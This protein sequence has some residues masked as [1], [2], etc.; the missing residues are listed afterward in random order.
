MNRVIHHAADTIGRRYLALTQTCGAAAL[1]LWVSKGAICSHCPPGFSGKPRRRTNGIELFCD[2]C[3]E[4]WDPVEQW[5]LRSGVN[6]GLPGTHKHRWERGKGLVIEPRYAARPKGGRQ[7]GRTD[8]S[9]A[10]LADHVD[11]LLRTQ[12]LVETVPAGTDPEA[13]CYAV[14]C[15]LALLALEPWSSDEPPT[16]KPFPGFEPGEGDAI[17]HVCSWGSV[18][19]PQLGPW[20]RWTQSSV[21]TAIRTAREWIGWRAQTPRWPQEESMDEREWVP[22]REAAQ[23]LGM[24]ERTLRD[25]CYDL[26]VPKAD[27]HVWRRPGSKRGGRMKI[28]EAAMPRIRALAEQRLANGANEANEAVP[29]G[30]DAGEGSPGLV[31]EARG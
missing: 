31:L 9:D 22:L 29:C 27:W 30:T 17:A 23:R 21:T 11:Q 6:R 3:N 24:P 12:R 26:V 25:W 8:Q 5:V 14:S 2:R 18:L 4:P 20:D 10:T 28:R 13:W 19:R 7:P 1:D 16:V 15:W